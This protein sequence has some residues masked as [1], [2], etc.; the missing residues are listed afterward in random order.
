VIFYIGPNRATVREIECLVNLLAATLKHLPGLAASSDQKLSLANGMMAFLHQIEL[1]REVSFVA[2][3]VRKGLG[4]VFINLVLQLSIHNATDPRDRIY[5]LLALAEH[6]FFDTVFHQAGLG[7]NPNRFMLAKCTICSGF[8]QGDLVIDYAADVVDVY[9]SLFRFAASTVGNLNLLSLCRS[10]LCYEERSW[11]LDLAK[12]GSNVV[13]RSQSLLYGTND[14]L[15]PS[16][17]P[18]YYASKGKEASVEFEG[19]PSGLSVWG[20]ICGEVLTD[21]NQLEPLD[22]K[23][24]FGNRGR[25]PWK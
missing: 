17:N 23:L 13:L 6:N 8:T 22:L 20:V 15:G 14:L 21:G 9:S 18:G 1:K 16:S 3:N 25:A 5:A 19:D 24:I 7:A 10:S 4:C 12:L 11:T 2:G